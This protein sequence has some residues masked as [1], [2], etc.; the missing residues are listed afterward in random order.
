MAIRSVS[1]PLEEVQQNLRS[2]DE[3]IENPVHS[4]ERP[5]VIIRSFGVVSSSPQGAFPPHL[6]EVFEATTSHLEDPIGTF[7]GLFVSIWSVSHHAQCRR[8]TASPLPYSSENRVGMR[9]FGLNCEGVAEPTMGTRRINC[10]KAR[11]VFGSTTHDLLWSGSVVQPR[12]MPVARCAFTTDLDDPRLG[13][14]CN[15]PP[16]PE[17]GCQG[18][19]IWTF[20]DALGVTIS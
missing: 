1:I 17:P 4:C 19:S 5:F 11:V 7:E 14:L 6:R 3:Y 10:E 13:V 9:Y 15:K 18:W 8:L 20:N 16:M 12:H 2:F